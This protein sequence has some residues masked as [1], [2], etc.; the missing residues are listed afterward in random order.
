MDAH[1]T[2]HSDRLQDAPLGGLQVLSRKDS[3]KLTELTLG[4]LPDSGEDRALAALLGWLMDR[5]LAFTLTSESG[6]VDFTGRGEPTL[7]A[8]TTRPAS[9]GDDAA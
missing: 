2:V 3:W 4:G 9:S 8:G 6:T 1:L 5:N 7:K